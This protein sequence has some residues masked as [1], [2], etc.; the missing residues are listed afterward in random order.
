MRP[1]PVVTETG[2]VSTRWRA[3]RR[4]APGISGPSERGREQEGA[5]L[6]RRHRDISVAGWKREHAALERRVE[7]ASHFSGFSEADAPGITLSLRRDER[8][9]MVVEHV[10][11]VEPGPD[12]V[13]AAPVLDTG[14]ATITD[15][16]VVFE[17]RLRTRE[18]SFARLVDA[19]HHDRPPS[20]SMEVDNRKRVSG[21][22]YDAVRASDVRFLLDLALAHH[23]GRVA[24]FRAGL[25]REFA[26][27]T[28]DRPGV[29][30][31]AWVWRGWA[32]PVPTALTVA[33]L[34]LTGAIVYASSG[35][36]NARSAARAATPPPNFAIP[37]PPVP[38]PSSPA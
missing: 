22:V 36:E 32:R 5:T 35:G 26:R 33:A 13:E 28:A 37:V 29:H 27:H 25:E 14:I 19:R 31:G 18:W 38:K 10:E 8:V 11:L 23:A 12:S 4:A 20:T 2:P 1:Q 34:I 9:F 3:S 17:G 16:R 21:I 15:Y 7:A 30:A 24:E 6:E